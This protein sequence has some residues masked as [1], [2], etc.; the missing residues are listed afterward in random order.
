[1]LSGFVLGKTRWDITDETRWDIADETR[2][3]MTVPTWVIPC[4]P[5]R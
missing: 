1:M 2:W 4:P 5:Y 3:D